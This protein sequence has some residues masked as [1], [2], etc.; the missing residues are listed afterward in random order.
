MSKLYVA[1][2]CGDLVTSEVLDLI[3]GSTPTVVC[4]DYNRSLLEKYPEFDKKEWIPIAPVSDC[5]KEI[6][7]RL[8]NGPVAVITSGDPLFFGLG[9][10]LKKRFSRYPIHYF[11]AVSTMQLCFSRFGISWD[12]AKILSLHGRDFRLLSQSLNE[13]KL[14]IFTDKNNSPQKV[15]RHLMDTCGRCDSG[16]YIVHVGEKLGMSDEMLYSGSLE[17]TAACTF[18]QPNCMILINSGSNH[19][20]NIRLGLKEEDL[21]HSRGLI[22]KNEVRAAA[23]HALALPDR[24]VLWDIGAGSGSISIE[25]ARIAPSLSVY[26]IEKNEDELKNINRNK[27]EYQCLNVT[28]VEGEAPDSLMTLPAPD[29]VFV[30]GSGGHLKEIISTVSA[31]A[32]NNSILV[33]TAVT[34]KTAREAPR[35]LHEA[36]YKVV[37]SLIKTT[38]YE[39][40]DNLPTDFNPIHLIVARRNND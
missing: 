13:E 9:R 24:G 34:P 23:L 17:E 8:K 18:S 20:S 11:P 14:F 39:Y 35:L 32:G 16:D 6:D 10:L 7:S 2:I 3:A 38:R 19:E 22:T 27:K 12:D 37:I 33:V 5:L 28:V 29:R 21:H 36:G 26:A 1:G 15:A 25:S 40:P 30:G 4:S 31:A